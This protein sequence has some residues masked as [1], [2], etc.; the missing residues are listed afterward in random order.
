MCSYKVK[1]N[2]TYVI[3]YHHTNPLATTGETKTEL[4]TL[5]CLCP[6]CHRVAHL[7]IP[8]YTVLELKELI[9]PS[10]TIQGSYEVRDCQ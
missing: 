5:V 1:I 9:V 4:D 2:E 3:D 8:P 6:N 7:K 10:Q